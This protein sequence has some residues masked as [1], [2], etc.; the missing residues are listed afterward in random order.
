MTEVTVIIPL[1]NKARSI[2]RA[3]DSVF[4]QTFQNF[5][6]VVVDDGSTDEGAGIVAQIR[7]PR[8]R[9]VRQTNAGP[10][11]ARNRGLT[12][13]HAK[14]AAF[15]D[16]DDEWLPGFLEKNLNSLKQHPECVAVFSR[17]LQGPEKTPWSP[18][19][20]TILPEGK[21]RLPAD[22]RPPALS[23]VLASAVPSVFCARQPIVNLGGFY[24]KHCRF[25]EDLFLWLLVCLNHPI[26][27]EPAP[28]VV[29]HTEDSGLN[30]Y[31]T[32]KN[33]FNSGAPVAQRPL[34]AWLLAPDRI[35]E[36]C[37]AEHQALLENFLAFDALSEANTRSSNGDTETA[38]Q[39]TRQYRLMN[40]FTW[41]YAKLR[42]KLSFPKALSLV[43]GH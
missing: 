32:T 10:G 25:G 3:L 29:Y 39:L 16:A 23:A 35:R 41:D 30:W 27:L 21:W 13:S 36:Q 26:Y 24:E 2:N 33:K 38:R 18:P 40:S 42:L 43:R 17:N 5:E 15:L 4:Q 11:A 14:Y 20:G 19:P 22:C 31:H 12:E 9:L 34:N 8:L 6:V 7:D 1:Y 37:P 28:L